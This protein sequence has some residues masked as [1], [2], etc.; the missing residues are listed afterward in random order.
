MCMHVY[1]RVY[2]CVLACVDMSVY[3][4]TCVHRYAYI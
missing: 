4:C 2:E 1:M 3:V